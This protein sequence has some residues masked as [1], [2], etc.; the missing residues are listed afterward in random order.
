NSSIPE[1]PCHAPLTADEIPWH[2]SRPSYAPSSRSLSYDELCTLTEAE[3]VVE[4]LTL[5]E[6]AAWICD[7]IRNRLE[8]AATLPATLEALNTALATNAK[9]QSR[10][11]VLLKVAA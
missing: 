1:E 4:T 10:L 7:E 8:L 5:T 2:R 11:R 3:G 9:L 6:T